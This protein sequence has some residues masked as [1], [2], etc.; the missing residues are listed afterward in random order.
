MCFH[1]AAACI[2]Q[3]RKAAVGMVQ[4]LTATPEGAE[5]LRSESEELLPA[6]LWLMNDE[7]QVSKAALTSLV[8]LSQVSLAFVA[9]RRVLVSASIVHR[10][11][12]HRS[13]N[14]WG[15][16]A[17]LAINLQDA[18]TAT[19][20]LGMQCIEKSVD[21]IRD[22]SVTASPELLTMLLTN[23]TTTE[24]GSERLLQI[25]KGDLEGFNMCASTACPSAHFHL[26]KRARR[27]VLCSGN[28]IDA[29][30]P[31]HSARNL[32]VACARHLARQGSALRPLC[33]F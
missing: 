32:V 5:Q 9:S 10:I 1:L 18:D 26:W 16:N 8:N 12:C 30:T 23:V 17:F 13:S 28:C 29:A 6:L 19:K 33:A 25:G 4:G 27:W 31:Q 21:Y 22:G 7:G 24:A 3:I 20:L 15:L 2:L 14:S 11:S